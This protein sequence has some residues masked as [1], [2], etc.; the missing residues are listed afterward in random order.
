MS[1]KIIVTLNNIMLAFIDA[2]YAHP[3]DYIPGAEETDQAME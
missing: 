2:A 1:S 3:D